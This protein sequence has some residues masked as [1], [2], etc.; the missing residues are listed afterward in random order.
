MTF[1]VIGGEVELKGDDKIFKTLWLYLHA[2]THFN[3][4]DISIC[5][6]EASVC[7]CQTT[8]NS[9]PEPM[10]DNLVLLARLNSTSAKVS[11]AGDSSAIA[12]PDILQPMSKLGLVASKMYFVNNES[13][14][15]DI[16]L[17]LSSIINLRHW[18]AFNI[19]GTFHH[20]LLFCQPG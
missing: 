14:W 8:L 6:T 2:L 11:G 19:Q 1:V 3:V 16:G 13:S 17:E 12:L 18:E 20:Q 15:G 7:P 4:S 5:A 9:S 10:V